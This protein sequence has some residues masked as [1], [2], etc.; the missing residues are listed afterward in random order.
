MVDMLRGGAC[1]GACT[2]PSTSG[3]QTTYMYTCMYM[4]SAQPT[5]FV[6]CTSTCQG[7]PTKCHPHS[8]A[9][10]S[11]NIWHHTFTHTALLHNS[12]HSC[13]AL[14]LVLRDHRTHCVCRTVAFLLGAARHKYPY[15]ELPLFSS[16]LWS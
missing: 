6:H 9:L 2:S 1:Y 15:S 10:N 4:Y 5:C 8:T 12:T 7:F 16:I 14:S 11:L 3:S 13:K